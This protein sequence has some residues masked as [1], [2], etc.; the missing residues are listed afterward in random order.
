LSSRIIRT[1]VLK[2]LRETLRDRRTLF[3]MVVIPVLLY[4]VMLVLMEQILVFGQRSLEA[5]APRVAVVGDG[6]GGRAFLERDA[7]LRLVH[8][9]TVPLGYL[10]SGQVAAIVVFPEPAGWRAEGTNEVRVL[11][12]GT[13]D[14]SQHAAGIVRQRLDAFG[15]ELLAGRL[16]ERG[17]PRAYAAPLAVETTSI[18]T[19]EQMGGYALGRFL[20]IL[21]I[22]MT[23]L[24]AFYPSIDLAAGEKERGTLETLLTAPVPADQIV[25]G[26]FV[27]AAL[28]G[29][30]A[31]SLNLGS[32]L[33]T[34]QSGLLSFGGALDLNFGLPLRSV[35]VILAVLLLLS[36]LFS[37]LFLGIAVRS[38]SF[39][40]AQNS[41]TP[42][43]ILSIL[44]VMLTM[45]P[46]LELT[47]TMALVPV[48]GV[49]FVF[50]DL[51]GGSLQPEPA[52]VAVCAT[53]VYAMMALVYAAKAFGREDVLFGGPGGD[54]DVTPLGA[55][56]RAWRRRPAQVPRAAEAMILVTFIALLFFY[57]GRSFMI[58]LGEAGIPPRSS[59]CWRCRCWSSW[60]SAATTRAARSRCA[61]PRR[62][63][64]APRC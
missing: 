30:T 17:L 9:D 55:R 49:A 25:T 48:G 60:R 7:S 11:Y 42:V 10:E 58:R 43:Y 31:A 19:A 37:A 6:G 1:V 23:V 26:K 2:E 13:A 32:M 28:M 53:V 24:G 34:F 59:S 45:M 46:G 3:V 21:L 50:R 57:L 52:I 54:V 40:E 38:H 63:P 64:S 41:L 62:A 22:L 4:P 18:A 36:V 35:L 14:H 5:S 39:K 56:V 44:P 16:E 12:D 27:A 15:D 29:F 51:M 33:L 20:P 47:T 61:A 8:T